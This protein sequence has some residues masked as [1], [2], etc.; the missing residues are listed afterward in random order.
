MSSVAWQG[1]YY[2]YYYYYYYFITIIFFFFL[3]KHMLEIDTQLQN[4]F[5][6]HRFF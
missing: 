6:T 4:I 5:D 3:V 2:Y 1:F